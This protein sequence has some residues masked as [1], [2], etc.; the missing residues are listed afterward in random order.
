MWQ[1]CEMDLKSSQLGEK[2]LDRFHEAYGSAVCKD[3][4][5]NCLGFCT[6]FVKNGVLDKPAFEKFEAAGGHD[7]VAPT[8]VGRAAAWAVDILWDELPGDQEI[9]LSDIPTMSEAEQTLANLK[10][11]P[12]KDFGPS[13]TAD[14]IHY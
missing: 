6:R 8:V 1:K 3:I 7:V 11:N 12:N 4:Q 2:L 13:K 10:S 9:D 5:T 14:N